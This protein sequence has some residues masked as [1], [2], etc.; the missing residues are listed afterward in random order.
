[1]SASEANMYI[2]IYKHICTYIYMCIYIY[3]CI[4]VGC[5]LCCEGMMESK[6][7]GSG[8]RSWGW[9]EGIPVCL[10]SLRLGRCGL[11]M[12][13]SFNDVPPLFSGGCATRSLIHVAG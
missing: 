13:M 8:T 12:D 1:M 4:R 11:K 2:Y 9:N 7:V 10:H 3:I 5:V 6:S